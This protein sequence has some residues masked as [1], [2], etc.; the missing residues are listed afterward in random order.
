MRGK[1]GLGS[2]FLSVTM[3]ISRINRSQSE[4]RY[5]KREGKPNHKDFLLKRASR[6]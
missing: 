6:G 2:F 4:K 3:A 5:R 1:E